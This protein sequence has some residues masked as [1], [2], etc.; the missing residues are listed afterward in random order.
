MRTTCPNCNNALTIKDVIR[1]TCSKCTSLEHHR[2]GKSVGKI[3]PSSSNIRTNFDALI[4]EELKK[5][6]LRPAA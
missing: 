1:N 4:S 2:P 3:S 5:R 6:T